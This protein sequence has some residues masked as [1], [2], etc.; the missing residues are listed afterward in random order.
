MSERPGESGGMNSG[1]PRAAATT[2][3]PPHESGLPGYT[4][5]PPPGA[6]GPVSP[7]FGQA[8]ALGGRYV[9]AGW[10]SRVAAQIVD[11]IIISVGAVILFVPVGAAFGLG[12]SAN[13]DAGIATAIAGVV[14]W[15]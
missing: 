1:A 13:S 15:V 7:A 3:P 12:A 4:S 6:G 14:L 2:D 11:G 8:P 9:L 5:P 10:W